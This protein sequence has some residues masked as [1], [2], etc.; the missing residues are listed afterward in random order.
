MREDNLLTYCRSNEHLLIPIKS[1]IIYLTPIPDTDTDMPSH[2][3]TDG[4]T[5]SMKLEYKLHG[6]VTKTFAK[7]EYE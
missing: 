3:G 6:M 7:E 4:T 1:E 2:T 5:I